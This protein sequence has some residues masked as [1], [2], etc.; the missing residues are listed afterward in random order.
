MHSAWKRVLIPRESYWFRLPSTER[1]FERDISC[2]VYERQWKQ[3]LM[4]ISRTR[5]DDGRRANDVLACRVL[6]KWFL[7]FQWTFMAAGHSFDS[8]LVVTDNLYCSLVFCSTCYCSSW[9]S[10][11]WSSGIHESKKNM[12]HH[13]GE[14][15]SWFSSVLPLMILESEERTRETPHNLFSEPKW[16][17]SCRQWWWCHTPSITR[18]MTEMTSL[19][20]Y[21]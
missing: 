13:W 21:E 5:L 12:Q 7:S 10:C 3:D 8:L 1:H 9:R 17:S 11:K 15:W 20:T 6:R 18:S 4:M 16:S 19:R 14:T 2:L